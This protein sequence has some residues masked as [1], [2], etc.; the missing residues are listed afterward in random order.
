MKRAFVAFLSAIVLVS[1]ALAQKTPAVD[2]VQVA[3]F[4]AEAIAIDSICDGFQV[5]ME[6]LWVVLQ[7]SKIELDEILPEAGAKSASYMASFA[8]DGVQ[9]VCARGAEYYGP[10]GSK[11]ANMLT[12]Q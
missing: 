6:Y 1:P 11:F 10:Q 12:L 2:K 7:R 4:L 9:Q 3:D 8:E 5:H